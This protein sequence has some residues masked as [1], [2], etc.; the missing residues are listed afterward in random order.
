MLCCSNSGRYCASPE[1]CNQVQSGF[2]SLLPVGKSVGV[3]QDDGLAGMMIQH[4]C[5]RCGRFCALSRRVSIV[6]D[7]NA[8]GIP[9]V[10]SLEN[11]AARGYEVHA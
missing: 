10:A 2:I 7:H 8:A 3:S 5:V 1:S 6:S 4:P 11:A 9:I